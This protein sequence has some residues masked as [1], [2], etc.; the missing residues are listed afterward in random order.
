MTQINSITLIS[1]A[2]LTVF[3]LS[4]VVVYENVESP[5][6]EHLTGVN[7]SLF[8]SEAEDSSESCHINPAYYVSF[9][10]LWIDSNLTQ[11]FFYPYNNKSKAIRAPPII[12]V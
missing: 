5:I 11:S 8:E 10:F 2:L 12:H 4:G 3:S 1:I 7:E 9:D 6:F